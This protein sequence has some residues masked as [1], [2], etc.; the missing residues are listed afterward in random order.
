MTLI[1]RASIE[2]L[3]ESVLDEALAIVSLEHAEL[4]A[5]TLLALRTALDTAQERA[6]KARDEALEA[7]A[8]VADVW[9]QTKPTSGLHAPMIATVI[10]DAANRIGRAIRAL[11]GEKA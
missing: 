1:D 6:D 2:R 10:C 5:A 9:T 4:V 7:A 8:K 11:K 3:A